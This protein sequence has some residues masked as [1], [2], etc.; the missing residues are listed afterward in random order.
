MALISEEYGCKVGWAT[1]DNEAEA[2]A[3]AAVEAE[4][5]EARAALGYDFGYQWPGS[6]ERRGE[7]WRVTTA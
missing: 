3:R 1:Y 5:R 7:C 6:I 4:R 2:Q